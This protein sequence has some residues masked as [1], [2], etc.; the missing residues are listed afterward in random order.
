MPTWSVA[1]IEDQDGMMNDLFEGL[2]DKEFAPHGTLKVHQVSNFDEALPLLEDRKIDIVILD[3]FLGDAADGD[4]AGVGVLDTWRERGFAPV[5][6]YSAA[7]ESVRP[8]EGPFIRIVNKDA[9]VAGEGS[10]AGGLRGLEAEIEALFGDKIPQ[11]HRAI[12][13]HFNKSLRDYM[14]GFVHEQWNSFTSLFESPDF[15]RLLVGRLALQFSREG[16]AEIVPRVYEGAIDADPRE[17]TVHPVEYYVRP[18]IGTDPKLGDLYRLPDPSALE[19]PGD[20]GDPADLHVLLW[21]SC[22]LVDR[23]GGCKVEN[24]IFA[25]LKK[26]ETFPEF[27]AWRDDHDR[28]GG[29]SKGKTNSLKGLLQGRVGQQDR[30]AFLPPCWDIPASCVDFQDLSIRKIDEF[31]EQPRVATIASP[32]AEALSAR[33]TRYV[34]RIG[35]ADLDHDEILGRLTPAAVAGP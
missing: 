1:V 34:G 25:R 2:H 5:I 22:D 11:L 30:Y 20:E 13:D 8:Q 6:V 7:P 19:A 29:P 9:A 16:I 10:K 23:G 18:P 35:T 12:S 14:W 4:A 27:S 24:A 21:P 33:F 26:L 17:D 31:K 28:E 3:L 15:L 32:F